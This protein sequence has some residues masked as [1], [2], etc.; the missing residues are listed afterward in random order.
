MKIIDVAELARASPPLRIVTMHFVESPSEMHRHVHLDPEAMETLHP[1]PR[2][3]VRQQAAELRTEPGTD[4]QPRPTVR[5]Q[6]DSGPALHS[7][8]FLP[9]ISHLR[10]DESFPSLEDLRAQ[11]R[12]LGR[13][14]EIRQ[15]HERYGPAIRR[16]SGLY[17]PAAQ[18]GDP[19]RRGRRTPILRPQAPIRPERRGKLALPPLDV[20]EPQQR[21]HIVRVYGAHPLQDRL[22]L[23][24][25][26]TR[27][28]LRVHDVTVPRGRWVLHP[29]RGRKVGETRCR[30]T[31]AVSAHDGGA[32]GRF[33]GA[34]STVDGAAELLRRCVAVRQST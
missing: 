8:V 13:R 17:P 25:Q 22:G 28:L 11:P 14:Q 6:G 21:L 23:L 32:E 10:G 9:S 24:E 2:Q 20:A 5:H 29:V 7:G 34:A 3:H 16:H 27:P 26:S 1:Q 12:L 18:D 31:V 30:G 33:R 19:P 15:P 4:G